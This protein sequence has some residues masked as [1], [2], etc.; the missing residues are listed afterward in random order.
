MVSP[1][2][3]ETNAARD[4]ENADGQNGGAPDGNGRG[5]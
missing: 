5:W 4:S 1:A 2:D 3:A